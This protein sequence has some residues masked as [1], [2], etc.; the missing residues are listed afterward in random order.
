MHQTNAFASPPGSALLGNECARV[1]SRTLSSREL[2][3][4]AF[5]STGYLMELD[6]PNAKL[7]MKGLE[8]YTV[9][10]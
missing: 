3:K 4:S 6:N 10:G 2:F 8:G 5:T 7:K 9:E 1:P